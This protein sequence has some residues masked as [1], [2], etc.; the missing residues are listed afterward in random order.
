MVMVMA[1]KSIRQPPG[2][3]TLWVGCRL[4][5]G[6][7]RF[8]LLSVKM[9]FQDRVALSILGPRVAAKHPVPAFSPP[10]MAITAADDRNLP[11]QVKES[12][13]R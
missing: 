8:L 9:A 12:E 3:M 5:H 2:D 10:T 1:G 6:G 7:G 13:W 11:K 4:S